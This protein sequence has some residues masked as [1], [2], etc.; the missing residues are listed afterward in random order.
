MKKLLIG[1]LLVL[2]SLE[3]SAMEGR[4]QPAITC[5]EKVTSET[6]R[7]SASVGY[8]SSKEHMTYTTQQWLTKLTKGAEREMVQEKTQKR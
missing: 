7:P 8:K 3:I 5:H 6:L 1:S 2:F 4:N